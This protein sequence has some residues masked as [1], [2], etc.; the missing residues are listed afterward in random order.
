MSLPYIP[1]VSPGDRPSPE[2]VI[3]FLEAVARVTPAFLQLRDRI[4]PECDLDHNRVPL[5]DV[6]AWRQRWHFDFENYQLREMIES[7]TIEVLRCWHKEPEHREAL[8][9]DRGWWNRSPKVVTGGERIGAQV[10]GWDSAREPFEVWRDRLRKNIQEFSR[11][12]RNRDQV[13]YDSVHYQPEN[14]LAF[15]WLALSVC[16]GFS[17]AKIAHHYR[18][19]K[20]NPRK[21]TPA[22][23]KKARQRLALHLGMG[24]LDTPR[25]C[26]H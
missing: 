21:A 17:D 23:V 15:E 18:D 22:A 9:V 7:W 5:A 20:A 16:C 26:P 24:T 25:Q 11:D 2:L 3:L 8:R 12:E 4:F 13:Q 1:P 10:R 19:R 6:D 14:S